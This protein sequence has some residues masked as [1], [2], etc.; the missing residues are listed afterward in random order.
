M[1]QQQQQ[2]KAQKDE[3]RRRD[4]RKN[5]KEQRKRRNKQAGSASWL[6]SKEPSHLPKHQREPH[7]QRFCLHCCALGKAMN[8]KVELITS[9]TK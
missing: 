4:A 8:H 5:N 2:E 3:S 7:D 1:K 9:H 6:A